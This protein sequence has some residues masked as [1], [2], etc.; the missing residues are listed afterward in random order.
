[1]GSVGSLELGD[2]V[3]GAHVPDV[4]TTSQVTEAGTEKEFALRLVD[5][6]VSRVLA[7][8]INRL[9]LEVEHLCSGGHVSIAN[10]ELAGNRTPSKV[11][12]RSLFIKL[13]QTV[14]GAIQADEVEIGF[15]II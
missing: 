8:R 13:N 3:T 9:G 1:M 4:Y 12:N 15:A 11:I 6:S 10:G 2:L 7:E 5:K 14:K